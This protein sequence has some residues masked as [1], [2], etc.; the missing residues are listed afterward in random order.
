MNIKGSDNGDFIRGSDHNDTIDGGKKNDW[1]DA[2][3]GDDRL[4]GGDGHD[5]ILA[6]P[7]HDIAWGGDGS[8]AIHAGDDDD[9]LYSDGSS[10]AFNPFEQRRVIPH[11][12]ESDDRLYGD[13]GRDTL[14]AGDGADVLTGGEDGDAFVFRFHDPMVGSTHCYTTVIDFAPEQDRFVMDAGDF[15]KGDL[16]GANFINHSKGFPGEFVDTFYNGKAAQAHGEHVVVITDQGFTSSS[17][18]ATAIP[19]EARGDIIVYHDEKTLG[20]DGK[21]HGATLAYVD[22]ANHAHAFAHVDNL[23]DMSDLTSLTAEN[24]GFI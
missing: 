21:T 10:A 4:T 22:S 13:K 8:D 1:I 3:N 19:G 24:F 7:G 14:V 16:F 6:G 12:G 15:G 17:A 20:Q 2:V 23:H 5:R 18:A 11:S 9:L